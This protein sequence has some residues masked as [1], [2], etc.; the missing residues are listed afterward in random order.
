M[1][2][3]IGAYGAPKTTGYKAIET[4]RRLEK[5]VRDHNGQVVFLVVM[6][7]AS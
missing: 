6:S 5:F 4:T 1:F 3:D 2:I 7:C